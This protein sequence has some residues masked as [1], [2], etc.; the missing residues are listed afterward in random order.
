MSR[1]TRLAAALAATALAAAPAL[2]QAHV[3][4]H[5]NVIP[6][7]AFA[8][9]V[10]RVPN[11]SDTARTTL[12]RMQLPD[13]FTSVAAAPPP[14]W[15]VAY[16]TQKLAKPIQGDDGP[17]TSEVREIDWAATSGQGTPPGQFLQLPISVTIPG[18]AGSVVTFPTVQTSSDGKTDRWIGPPSADNPAP[19]IDVSKAGG[20]LLDVAGGEAG[21][22]A[23]AASITLGANASTTTPSARTAGAAGA[24]KG[25]A[26]TALIVGILGLLAGLGGLLAARNARRRPA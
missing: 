9:L 20:P 16:K 19:T 24:S 10:V 6:S 26:I 13:G 8:T 4:L 11:E 18:S 15:S 1:R 17:V 25:L 23:G 7:G 14:G 5:P 21:P 3:S 2:A 22:R 12:V